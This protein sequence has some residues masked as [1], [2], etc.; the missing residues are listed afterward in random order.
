MTYR[1]AK[2]F[3]GEVSFPQD[4]TQCTHWDPVH[5]AATFQSHFKTRSRLWLVPFPPRFPF[6]EGSQRSFC[7]STGDPHTPHIQTDPKY[8]ESE[9]EIK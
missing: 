9:Q 4:G 5:P 6:T 1:P 7:I 8:Y 3:T 2:H